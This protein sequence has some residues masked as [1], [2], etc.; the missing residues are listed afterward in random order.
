MAERVDTV[1]K[2]VVSDRGSTDRTLDIVEACAK[3]DDRIVILHD[4]R[5]IQSTGVNR[6]VEQY[7]QLARFIFPVGYFAKLLASQRMTGATSVAVRMIA[8]RT[9]YYQYKEFRRGRAMTLLEQR[10]VPRMRQLLLAMIGPATAASLL[11]PVSAFFA[12]SALCWVTVCTAYGIALGAFKKS[13]CACA[14]GTA[15]LLM[16]LGFSLGFISQVFKLR[17]RDGSR[18]NRVACQA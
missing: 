17:S 12:L 4:E 15:A 5:R 11:R 16:H 18:S 6:D 7:G 14:A 13:N 9:T 3:R 8:K 10:A 1:C 2:I